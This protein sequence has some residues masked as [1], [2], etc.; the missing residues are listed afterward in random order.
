MKK[1]LI[2]F[3]LDGVLIDS[4]LNMKL[5]WNATIKKFK[6]QNSFNEYKKFIGIPFYDILDNLNITK[7]KYLIKKEYEQKSVLYSNKINLFPSVKK[8]LI[9]IQKK[10]LTSIVTSKNSKKTKI[11][12]DKFNIKFDFISTPSINLRGKPAPDQILY[13]LSKIN[14][15]PSEAIFIGDTIYDRH[16]ANRAKI[17]FIYVNYGFGP[18]LKKSPDN[19][20]SLTKLILNL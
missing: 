3:D 14:I 5:S 16:A 13:S 15:D 20:N 1:K 4:E 8:N 10:Y 18:K 19:F 12:L 11:I 6:I 17:E 2:I 9:K 7:N